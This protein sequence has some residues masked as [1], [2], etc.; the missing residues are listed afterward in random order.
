MTCVYELGEEMQPKFWCKPGTV[1]TCAYHIITTSEE[2][3]TVQIL[4]LGQSCTVGVHGDHGGP[5]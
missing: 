2:Q 3:P 5:G 4:H 1:Y